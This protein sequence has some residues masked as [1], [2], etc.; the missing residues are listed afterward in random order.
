MRRT[1]TV[2]L[3]LTVVV[4]A[5]AGAARSNWR[6]FNSRHYHVHTDI[7]SPLAEELVVRLDGMYDEYARRLSGFG[8]GPGNDAARSEVHLFAR[9]HDFLEFTR[10]THPNSTGIFAP[11]ADRLAAYLDS[12]ASLRRTLQHEGFHQFA[13][14]AISPELPTWLNEGMAVYF[15][16]ALWTGKSFLVGQVTPD[17]LK[18]LQ[19]DVRNDRLIPFRELLALTQEQWN[20]KAAADPER[21]VTQYNQSWAMVHFLVHG[22][23]GGEPY[24][25]RL[26]HLLKLIQQGKPAGDAFTEAFSPNVEGFQSRFV[27]FASQLT[28]T[29]EATMLERQEILA[30][31]LELLHARG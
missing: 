3:L 15:E 11:G 23:N 9:K 27:E 30:Q 24:R 26:L 13:Y 22:R 16:E 4:A 6:R 14:H 19:A 8:A 21:S 5:S 29:E 10:N 20:E 18:R 2:I 17:R 1:L 28:A 31:M 25:P 12:R 7:D